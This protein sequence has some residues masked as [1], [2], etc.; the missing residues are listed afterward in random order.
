[1]ATTVFWLLCVLSALTAEAAVLTTWLVGRVLES[2]PVQMIHR[3]SLFVGLVTGI[4]ALL[5]VP[6]VL[7][8]RPTRPPQSALNL[9]YAAAVVAMLMVVV[10]K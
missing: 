8:V 6:V 10:F 1:V 7:R 3:V 9:T 4:L 5:T 2:A